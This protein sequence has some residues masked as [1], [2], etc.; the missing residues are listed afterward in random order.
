MGTDQTAGTGMRE[1]RLGY[2]PAGAA[3]STLNVKML[4]QNTDRGSAKEFKLR[5]PPVPSVPAYA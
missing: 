1:H 4:H 2:P 3:F 5:L